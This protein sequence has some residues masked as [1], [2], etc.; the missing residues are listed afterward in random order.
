M[1]T[2][3]V[4][5]RPELIAIIVRK[6]GLPTEDSQP[7]YLSRQQLQSLLLFIENSILERGRMSENLQTLTE[8][9]KSAYGR[10]KS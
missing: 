9:L 3:K 4:I 6:A 10:N 5:R 1:K 2:R 7:G 8:R